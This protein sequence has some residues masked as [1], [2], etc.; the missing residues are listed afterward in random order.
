MLACSEAR[1]AR[2]E[3]VR[4]A[5]AGALRVGPVGS[6]DG[7]LTARGAEGQEVVLAAVP[8]V[9]AQARLA[10]GNPVQVALQGVDLACGRREGY[11]QHQPSWTLTAH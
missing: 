9:V 1:V 5:G 10:G 11:A 2:Q 8:D 6:A 7:R 3:G 4:S